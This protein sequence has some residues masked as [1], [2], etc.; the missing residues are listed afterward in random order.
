M[1]RMTHPIPDL[2]RKGL[3]EFGIVTGAIVAGL[4]GV[5]IPWAFDMPWPRWPWVVFA[6]LGAWGLIAPASLKPVY[7]TWMRFGLLMGTVMTPLVMGIV[8]FFVITPMAMALKLLG[9]DAMAR[10]FNNEGSYRIIS[11]SAS[12][13]SLRRPY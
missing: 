1:A 6:V 4:F 11:K 9:K 12:A 7:R 10:E 2:D 13:D 3:R 5:A 8:F